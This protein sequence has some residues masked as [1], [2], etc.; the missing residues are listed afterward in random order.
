MTSPTAS[1]PP[2]RLRN[3]MRAPDSTISRSNAL[4]STVAIASGARIDEDLR[5]GRAAAIVGDRVRLQGADERHGSRVVAREGRLELGGDTR[6]ERPDGIGAD[7]LHERE[8]QPAA[9]APR[10]A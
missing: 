2:G 1:A 7:P 9:D 8:Q 10:H 6:L 3:S 4:A 5:C